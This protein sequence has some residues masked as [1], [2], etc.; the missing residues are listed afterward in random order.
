MYKPKSSKFNYNEHMF[1]EEQRLRMAEQMREML[2]YFDYVKEKGEEET[3]TRF[4]LIDK[5]TEAEKEMRGKYRKD[6]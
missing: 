5:L 3:G 1:T 4:H 6:N 2:V